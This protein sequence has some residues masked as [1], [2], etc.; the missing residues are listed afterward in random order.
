[1]EWLGFWIFASTVFAC[2]TVLAV[3]QNAS[4]QKKKACTEGDH[5]KRPDLRSL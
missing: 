1:M 4:G 3:F 2:A 5:S